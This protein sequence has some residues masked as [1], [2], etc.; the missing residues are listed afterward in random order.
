MKVKG[1]SACVVPTIRERALSLVVV[2]CPA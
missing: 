1:I 2:C